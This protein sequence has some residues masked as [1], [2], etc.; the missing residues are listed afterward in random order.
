M[1]CAVTMALFIYIRVLI[2][3]LVSDVFFCPGKLSILLPK[4]IVEI[5]AERKDL[6]LR[7]FIDDFKGSPASVGCSSE[8]RVKI[9]TGA[10]R[11]L[12]RP[13]NIDEKS[14]AAPDG[15]WTEKDV[16]LLK[17]EGQDLPPHWA[18]MDD[19]KVGKVSLAVARARLSMC[20]RLNFLLRSLLLYFFY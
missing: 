10:D 6:E 20:D 18:K 9:D 8:K 13:L 5:L 12:A 11:S 3:V 4:L 1:G 15:D 16:E 2:Y 7:N 19:K 14:F 17:H